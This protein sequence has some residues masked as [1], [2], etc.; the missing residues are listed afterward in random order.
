MGNRWHINDELLF[1][2][3]IITSLHQCKEYLTGKIQNIILMKYWTFSYMDLFASMKSD[4]LE[5]K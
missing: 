1:L 3:Y 5:N 2:E 4:T